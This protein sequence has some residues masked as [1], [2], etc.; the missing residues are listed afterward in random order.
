MISV[1]GNRTVD[2]KASGSFTPRETNLAATGFIRPFIYLALANG[3][4]ASVR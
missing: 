2:S 3:S 4:S 1:A